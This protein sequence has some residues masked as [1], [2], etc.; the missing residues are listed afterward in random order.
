MSSLFLKKY[1]I[2]IGMNV[3]IV[4]VS[5]CVCLSLSIYPLIYTLVRTIITAAANNHIFFQLLDIVLFVLIKINSECL[6]V[7]LKI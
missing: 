1:F 4:V 2:D 5:L 3:L 7:H 6:T